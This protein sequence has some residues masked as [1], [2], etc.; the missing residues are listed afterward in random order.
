MFDLRPEQKNGEHSMRIR[1]PGQRPPR[2]DG[3]IKPDVKPISFKLLSPHPAMLSDEA[4]L[5]ECEVTFGKSGGPGG[6]HR[7]KVE[8]A[9]DLKHVPS[10]VIASA[11]ERRRQIENRS[12]ALKRLR[13]KLAH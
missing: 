7:N 12:M 11:G 9:C 3:P 4:L 2:K 6:Q 5:K 8:T 1:K 13:I 10:E